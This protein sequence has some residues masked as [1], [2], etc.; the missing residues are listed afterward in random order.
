MSHVTQI[1]LIKN[2]GL[3]FTR[4]IFLDFQIFSLVRKN[5]QHNFC[6]FRFKLSVHKVFHRHTPPLRIFYLDF[7]FHYSIL[8]SSSLSKSKT[9][10]FARRS[11]ICVFICTHVLKYSFVPTNEL[12]FPTKLTLSFWIDMTLPIGHFFLLVSSLNKAMFPTL[13]FL[14]ILSH[15]WRTC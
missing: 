13:K 10:L 8:F 1:A 2:S 6:S 5:T 7:Y 4:I 12:T 9:S 15:L 14:T 3:R 11:N